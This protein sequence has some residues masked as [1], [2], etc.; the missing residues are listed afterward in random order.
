[1]RRFLVFGF[2]FLFVLAALSAVAYAGGSPRYR[3]AVFMEPIDSSLP[4]GLSWVDMGNIRVVMKAAGLVGVNDEGNQVFAYNLP[5]GYKALALYPLDSNH[6]WF[7]IRDTSGNIAVQVIDRD[8]QVA[9]N[10]FLVPASD[11]EVLVKGIP[12][13]AFSGLSIVYSD[14]VVSVGMS[15]G[16]TNNEFGMNREG[17]IARVHWTGS[18]VVLSWVHTYYPLYMD[19]DFD[20]GEEEHDVH[21]ILAFAP[22]DVSLVGPSWVYLYAT[23]RYDNHYY[24]DKPYYW[25]LSVILKINV[26]DGSLDHVV[27]W[28]DSLERY[29]ELDDTDSDTHFGYNWGH[30]VL[31]AIAYGPEE[32][33]FY[34]VGMAWKL[35]F[36]SESFFPFTVGSSFMSSVVPCEDYH[37]LI[38]AHIVGM[39]R[40]SNNDIAVLMTYEYSSTEKAPSAGNVLWVFKPGYSPLWFM[41]RGVRMVAYM[42]RYQ[43]VVGSVVP[44]FSYVLPD[45]RFGEIPSAGTDTFWFP[46]MGGFYKVH[47]VGQLPPPDVSLEGNYLTD[48]DG[49][50]VVYDGKVYASYQYPYEAQPVVVGDVVMGVEEPQQGE[51]VITV[52]TA[53]AATV[54]IFME[55]P[56][57][58]TLVNP[59]GS[60]DHGTSPVSEIGPLNI[61]PLADVDVSLTPTLMFIKDGGVQFELTLSKGLPTDAVVRLKLDGADMGDVALP[62]GETSLSVGVSQQSLGTHTLTAAVCA[63]SGLEE[64]CTEVATATAEWIE[65]FRPALNVPV[66]DV[67]TQKLNFTVNA[68]KGRIHI[69]DVYSG[70]PSEL[71]VFWNDG[72]VLGASVTLPAVAEYKI[73]AYA[74]YG[75]YQ[76]QPSNIVSV[77]RRPARPVV[78]GPSETTSPELQLEITA[79]EGQLSVMLDGTEVINAYHPGG[80]KAYTVD[81]GM[82]GQHAI[83]A[84]LSVNGI[85]SPPSEPLIVALVEQPGVPEVSGIPDRTY[86]REITFAVN[87]SVSAGYLDV[88]VDGVQV[89]HSAVKPGDVSVTVRLP[90]RG[91]HEISVKICSAGGACSEPY[92]ERV[93]VYDLIE[94][95]IGRRDYRINGRDMQM[96][97]APFIDPTV[98]RTMVPLRFILEGLGFQVGWD[99]ANR[100]ITI[101][102][103]V[104]LED[105]STVR[106]VVVMS[107]PK[108]KPQKRGG[109]LVY[110]GSP[111]VVVS[112]DG[113]RQ[114][115]VDMRNY[116]GQDMGIPF[117]YQNRT[118][119]PVRFI[120]EIFG[121]KVGWNGAER[122]V[123]IE[124]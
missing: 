106:R 13:S 55:V 63:P 96:D 43:A 22:G 104:T 32:E 30:W 98:G 53:T 62:A 122:K 16:E 82:P 64:V 119:V 19:L 3:A 9:G 99:G 105:G 71:G 8:G 92:T 90:G 120:S 11:K 33:N 85:K 81:L 97:V 114:R 88:F 108:T 117:I 4:P 87:V 113:G 69:V 29:A 57:D 91:Y 79:S 54:K 46:G 1:M 5:D 74:E 48:E 31:D 45:A 115:Q 94:M 24:E 112:D 23:E 38:D 65:M 17:I 75:G 35:A 56:S 41:E 100:Q 6:V 34:L 47:I 103:T 118:Y 66:T 93:Y 28:S 84:V 40:L 78:S 77:I 124:R 10:R 27:S 37:K 67:D 101:T 52:T 86:R 51:L 49:R 73:Y 76:S 111:I 70:S 20:E 39:K 109:Y 21:P 80:T 110:P 72:G 50:Y 121:A 89:E 12:I 68:P 7:I 44:N 95:W 14:L 36:V 26:S 83:T 107:M 15:K 18:N 102:G 60:A 123:T 42:P 25:E 116:N 59:D 61:F 2:L 58:M